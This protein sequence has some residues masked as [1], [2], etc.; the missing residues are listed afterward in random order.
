LKLTTARRKASSLT[1]EDLENICGKAEE[2]A[3]R[4]ILSRV[5]RNKVLYLTISVDAERSNDGEITVDVD[6][7]VQLSRTMRGFNVKKL[8][9]EAVEESF[10]VLDEFFGTGGE[11]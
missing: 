1:A 11:G 3:R 9:N 2:A 10:R 4:Y 6:V 5:P 8:V 7:E